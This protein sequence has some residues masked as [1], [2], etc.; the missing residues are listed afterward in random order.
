MTT[1]DGFQL[2]TAEGTLKGLPCAGVIAPDSKLS[3][4]GSV[5]DVAVIGAGY[6]GLI[7]ARDLAYRGRF[8]FY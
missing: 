8:D 6:A 5:Y 2:K 7:A 4:S 3:G 1:R